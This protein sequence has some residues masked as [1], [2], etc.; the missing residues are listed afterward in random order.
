MCHFNNSLGGSFKKPFIS[1]NRLYQYTFY[2]KIPFL[3]TTVDVR[4]CG[5][6]LVFFFLSLQNIFRLFVSVSRKLSPI[7]CFCFFTVLRRVQ[8]FWSVPAKILSVFRP[9]VEPFFKFFFI[10]YLSWLQ[11]PQFE[12]F[13][14]VKASG[15]GS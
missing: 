3:F 14:T 6:H 8:I 11:F 2:I 5:R 9:L 13:L 7:F 1:I 4:G 10:T 15:V 12:Q